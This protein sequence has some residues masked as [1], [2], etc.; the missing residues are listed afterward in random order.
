MSTKVVCST[1]DV[2]HKEKAIHSH[3]YS[4]GFVFL[5]CLFNSEFFITTQ[6]KGFTFD[7]EIMT[8]ISNVAL[9]L[10]FVPAS[11]YYIH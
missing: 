3:A 5:F 11:G 10:M 8:P 2:D 9:M 4:L 1:E 6:K 7:K